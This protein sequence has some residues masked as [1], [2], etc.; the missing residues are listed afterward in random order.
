[1]HGAPGQPPESDT[2]GAQTDADICPQ[3]LAPLHACAVGLEVSPR[4]IREHHLLQVQFTYQAFESRVLLLQLLQALGLDHLHAPLLTP[5]AVVA[6]IGSTGLSASAQYIF[7]LTYLDLYLAQLGH[8]LL[9][10]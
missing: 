9:G 8:N 5:P 2:L 3:H 10:L 4:N 7:A 1:L 6:L